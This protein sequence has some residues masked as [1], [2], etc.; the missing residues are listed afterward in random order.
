MNGTASCGCLG[1]PSLSSASPGVEHDLLLTTQ[2]SSIYLYSWAF[3]LIRQHR[4]E[5]QPFP[6]PENKE[7]FEV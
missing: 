1:W 5:E 2:Q 6:I 3:S 7:V 4:E